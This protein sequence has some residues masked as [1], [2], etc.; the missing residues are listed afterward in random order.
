MPAYDSPS[1]VKGTIYTYFVIL[2]G[3]GIFASEGFLEVLSMTAVQSRRLK[4][5]N[6]CLFFYRLIGK[7][8]QSKEAMGVSTARLYLGTVPPG[9]AGIDRP[10]KVN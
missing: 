5:G 7:F 3:L 9:A 1:S 2:A 10:R 4:A 6:F 8:S